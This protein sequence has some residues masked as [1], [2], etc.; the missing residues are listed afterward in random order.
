MFK[1]LV[2]ATSLV[3]SSYAVELTKQWETKPI[4]KVPESVYLDNNKNLLYVANINGKPTAKDGN[5]FISILDLNGDIKTL[6]FAKGLD[7]PKGMDIYENKL[8]VSD[9]DKLRI[10]DLSNGKI[11]KSYHIKQAKFLNDVVVSDDGVIY[12][13]DFSPK[14]KAIY[15]IANKK[16][17]KWLDEKQLLGQRPNGLWLEKSSLVIGTK[18]G[19]IF[20]ANL[21]TKKIKVYKAHIGVNGID[22]ILPFDENSYITSDWAG[23]IFISDMKKSI[24]L[25]DN[26]SKKI[27]A[28]D[29]WYDRESKRVYIPTFFDNR[30]LC[31]EIK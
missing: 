11:I 26:T 19:S 15:K 21:K 3:I 25:L 6:E 9:I 29:I 17:I 23:R 13:S 7:A 18:S 12:V 14:N 22:G 8:Y 2:I 10:I 16:I 4:L 31:F 24:K 28:A 5:G 20:K 30:V 27:N 1:N